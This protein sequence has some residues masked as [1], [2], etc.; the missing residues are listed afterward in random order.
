MSGGKAGAVAE[1]P[2]AGSRPG[3]EARRSRE[4][5][6][7]MARSDAPGGGA[8]AGGAPAIGRY[9]GRRVGPGVFAQAPTGRERRR[10]QPPERSGRASA[11]RKAGSEGRPQAE[12]SGGK[13]AKQPRHCRR[14]PGPSETPERPGRRSR[15][16]DSGDERRPGRLPESCNRRCRDTA[17]QRSEDRDRPGAHLRRRH[18]S[19]GGERSGLTRF[20]RRGSHAQFRPQPRLRR[21]GPSGQ[22]GPAQPPRQGRGRGNAGG[23]RRAPAGGGRGGKGQGPRPGRPDAAVRWR[24]SEA[25][26]QAGRGRAKPDGERHRS[27]PRT[28]DKPGS[29]RAGKRSKAGE[30]AKA[31]SMINRQTA[32]SARPMRSADGRRQRTGG[33]SGPRGSAANVADS[34]DER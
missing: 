30:A 28:I 19:P 25:P 31:R 34:G 17:R 33:G 11:R 10:P 1:P 20:R 3:S 29:E 5:G 2:Q 8:A 12:P 13:E 23:Y 26:R 16:D 18:D 22:A 6:R 4:A 15:R 9:P 24:E 7:R 27:G 32:A 14:R 21:A